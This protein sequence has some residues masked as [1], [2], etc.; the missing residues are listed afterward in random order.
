MSVEERFKEFITFLE[1]I[2][3]EKIISSNGDIC[4]MK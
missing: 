1:D 3:F 2:G 4:R